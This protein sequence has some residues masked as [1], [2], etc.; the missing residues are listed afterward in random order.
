MRWW[1]QIQATALPLKIPK[2]GALTKKECIVSSG[3]D[4]DE[5]QT[6]LKH[7]SGLIPTTKDF[8]MGNVI[9]IQQLVG[10]IPGYQK[11]SDYGS[12]NTK[13]NLTNSGT[14]TDTYISIIDTDIDTDVVHG[15][16]SLENELLWA[17]NIMIMMV[18]G[19]I[20][21]STSILILF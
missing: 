15:A 2:I 9:H 17:M 18:V 5:E 7:S 20:Y 14:D 6:L 10:G 19:K 13:A 16:G 12:T 4:F 8:M 21:S 3:I 11:I 1:I